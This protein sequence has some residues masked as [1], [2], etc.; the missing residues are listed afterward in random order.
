LVEILVVVLI[1]GMVL[2][3]TGSLM[4]GF[5]SLFE[6]ADDQTIASM[7][8]QDVFKV[9]STPIQSSGIGIPKNELAS[10]NDFDVYFEI[11]GKKAPIADWNYGPVSI[12]DGASW[13]AARGDKM[14][15]V[16][17]IPSG[18]KYKSDVKNETFKGT[19]SV[20]SGPVTA[21]LE[22]LGATLHSNAALPD[23]IIPGV[24]DVRSFVTFPGISRAPLLVD[25]IRPDQLEVQGKRPPEDTSLDFAEGRN[26]ILPYHDLYLVRAAVAY[27]RNGTFCLVDVNDIDPSTAGYPPASDDRFSGFR[28]EG[29]SAVLFEQDPNW[30]FLTV[31]I[32]AEGDAANSS[33]REEA[34]ID[35]IMQALRAVSPDIDDNLHLDPSMHYEYFTRTYRTRNL[36]R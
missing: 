33:R 35:R 31:H 14:R 7:R 15:V 3:V 10:S 30:R 26:V 13:H 34:N 11:G 9:L 20:P 25:N 24:G 6:N 4:S 29:I 23:A 28:V 17:S 2:G 5:F 19:G 22:F 18:A 1:M 32:V 36:Q 21:T 12:A 8:A 16:Y 27:V